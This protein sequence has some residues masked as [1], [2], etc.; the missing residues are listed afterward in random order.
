M[1]PS[2]GADLTERMGRF[3]EA[4][5][6]ALADAGLSGYVLKARSPSCGMGEVEVWSPRGGPPRRAGRGLFAEALLRIVPGLPVEEE[7]GLRDPES[8]REFLARVRAYHDREEEVPVSRWL[9]KTDPDTY[10]FA[11]LAREG[12]TRWEG[13]KNALARRHLS[14]MKRGDAVLVYETGGVKAV[15]GMATVAKGPYPDAGSKDPKAV[16]V[17][18]RAGKA[19]PSPVPLAAAKSDPVLAKSPLVRMGRLSVMPVTDEEWARLSGGR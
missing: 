4:R 19:L 18:L 7:E 15:V 5:V 14:S 1:R 9:V 17:D 6:R 16:V 13:V 11:D 12:T 10:S 3:A 8:R 2:D